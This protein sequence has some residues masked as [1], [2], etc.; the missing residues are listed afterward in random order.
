MEHPISE[1]FHGRAP[2]FCGRINVVGRMVH[3]RV[4][5]RVIA[6]SLQETAAFRFTACAR[7]TP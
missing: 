1:Q 7:G 6:N 4:G 5:I 2:M 3:G